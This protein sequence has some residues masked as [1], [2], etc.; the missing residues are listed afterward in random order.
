MLA[1]DGYL[2]FKGRYKDMLKTSGINVSTLEVEGF[3]E[4]YPGVQEVQVV[5]IPDEIK[6]EVGVAFVKVS[7]GAKITEE[8][9][10]RYCQKNIASYKIPRYFC[11]AEE[12]PRTGSGKVKKSELRD[13]F[14][15]DLKTEA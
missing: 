3:L 10:I 15:H 14:L 12:F 1:Q 8:E 4:S 6:E 13:R 9:L 11:F 2:Q 7:P 5:G